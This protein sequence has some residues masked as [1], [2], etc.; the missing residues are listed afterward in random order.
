V[1]D[2]ETGPVGFLFN[3]VPC[4]H[5]EGRG[6]RVSSCGEGGVAYRHRA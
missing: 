1:G 5:R 4:E 2:V 3:R 6:A